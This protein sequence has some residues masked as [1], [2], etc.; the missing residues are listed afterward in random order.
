MSLISLSKTLQGWK[1]GLTPLPSLRSKAHKVIPEN[2]P[3]IGSLFAFKLGHANFPTCINCLHTTLQTE[4]K[5]TT[6]FPESLF[7]PLW[8]FDLRLRKVSPNFQPQR[9]SLRL[10]IN[11]SMIFV[12]QDATPL[13]LGQE[14]SSFVQQIE[15][16]IERVKA[17]LP[18]LYQL[19]S[20][21]N[22][23]CL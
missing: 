15:N 19:A 22:K 4:I 7:E 3:Y 23:L 21:K 9:A 6:S 18:H 14:F 8:A 17:T 12:K 20:G 13:T 16:G 5:Y 2:L 1:F 11:V 10:A